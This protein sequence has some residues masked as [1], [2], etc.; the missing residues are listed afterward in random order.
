MNSQTNN[1]VRETLCE[2]LA[3]SLIIIRNNADDSDVCFRHADHVHNLP[4]LISS[5]KPQLLDFYWN[6]ERPA[7]IRLASEGEIQL[8]AASW[9]K[10][11][12][13]VPHPTKVGAELSLAA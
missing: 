8:F 3:F 9:Q 2:I 4:F 6:I 1:A 11:E 10:L 7:F 13:F 12:A 5:Q